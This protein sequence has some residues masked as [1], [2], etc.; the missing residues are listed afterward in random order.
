VS[1]EEERA[2]RSRHVRVIAEMIEYLESTRWLSHEEVRRLAEMGFYPQLVVEEE[3]ALEES[4][5]VVGED[6]QE[7]WDA[8]TARE[9]CVAS[10]ARKFAGT[11]RGRRLGS[12]RRAA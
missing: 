3:P 4:T 6:E 7:R 11:R 8:L 2:N 5:E 10:Q 1:V 12:L 9:R